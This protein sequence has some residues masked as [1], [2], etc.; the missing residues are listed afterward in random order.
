MVQMPGHPVIETRP[1][2]HHHITAMHGEIGLIGAVHAQHA[3]VLR[4]RGRERA[5]A[6]QGS[7]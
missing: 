7:G 6:H 5:E 4:V 3:E 2:A 1:D